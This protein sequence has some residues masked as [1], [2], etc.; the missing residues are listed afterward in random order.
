MNR[1]DR[2]ETRL[3]T[4]CILA[5]GT[6]SRLFPLTESM[7][8]CLTEVHGQPLLGRLIASLREQ[9]F[10]RLV[11]VLGHLE[12]SIRSFL[13]LHAADLTIDYVSNP[14]FATT[15]NI[16]SLWLAREKLNEPFL[17]IESDLIFDT[18]LLSALTYPDRI[19]VSHRLPWMR[20]TMVTTTPY[21]WLVRS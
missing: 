2:Q 7:P 4:A 14:A 1:Y 15:N 16:Y 19:A 8:K 5:A 12:D 3:K 18:P 10:K 13:E 17:L 20:G 9:G 21:G 6:G 11:F